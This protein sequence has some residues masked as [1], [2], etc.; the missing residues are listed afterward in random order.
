[1]SKKNNKTTTKKQVRMIGK[2]LSY[3]VDGNALTINDQTG[4]ELIFFQIVSESDE[5]VEVQ[6]VASLR[7][8]INRLKSLSDSIVDT[9]KRHEE[10]KKK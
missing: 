3:A 10:K 7:M 4:A 2:P 9:I 5:A 6:G 1:M 8:D